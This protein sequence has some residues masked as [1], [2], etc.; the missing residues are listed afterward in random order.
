MISN[1]GQSRGN[2]MK[3]KLI[4]ESLEDLPTGASIKSIYGVLGVIRLLAGVD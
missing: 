4:A 1:M 3:K 2:D